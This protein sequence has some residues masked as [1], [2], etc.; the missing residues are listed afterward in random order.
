MA[1]SEGEQGKAGG[2]GGDGHHCHK[3]GH[4]ACHGQGLEQ[5]ICRAEGGNGTLER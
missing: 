4:R 5:I 2:I 3:S 1:P